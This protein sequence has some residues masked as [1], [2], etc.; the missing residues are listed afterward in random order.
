[1]SFFCRVYNDGSCTEDTTSMEYGGLDYGP[2]LQSELCGI[3][4]RKNEHRYKL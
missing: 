3:H 4:T 1:M 2:D